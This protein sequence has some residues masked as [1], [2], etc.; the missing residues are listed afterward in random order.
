MYNKLRTLAT[1]A[2]LAL[3][4]VR[5]IGVVSVTMVPEPGV[6]SLD[7]PGVDNHSRA[8]EYELSLDDVAPHLRHLYPSLGLRYLSI[9]SSENVVEINGELVWYDEG[10][11]PYIVYGRTLQR[12]EQQR[13]AFEAE[14]A[15]R[16]KIEAIHSS[17]R[18][19]FNSIIS[20]VSNLIA[21]TP[22][23][24]FDFVD[25]TNFCLFL[26]VILCLW[27]YV[28][29]VSAYM[30]EVLVLRCRASSV[31]RST[32]MK[33]TGHYIEEGQVFLKCE[34]YLGKKTC[35]IVLDGKVSTAMLASA[36]TTAAADA[37]A[38][39]NNGTSL[40]MSTQNASYPCRAPAQSA[41]IHG[42]C[43]K[44]NLSGD[45]FG[46]M[47]HL[48]VEGKSYAL[49]A[50]HVFRALKQQLDADPG[51]KI[52]VRTRNGIDVPLPQGVVYGMSPVSSMDFLLLEL[53]KS[54]WAVSGIKSIKIAKKPVQRHMK[55][56]VRT[57]NPDGT[58]RCSYGSALEVHGPQIF[59]HSASTQRGASGSPIISGGVCYGIHTRALPDQRTNVATCL[60]RLLRGS[61]LLESEEFDSLDGPEDPDD[62]LED[63]HMYGS[64]FFY[65]LKSEWREQRS[66]GKYF[67][68]EPSEEKSLVDRYGEE[69][70]LG[71][72]LNDNYV[73]G[74][75]WGDYE[76]GYYESSQDFQSGPRGQPIKT[77][78]P[79]EQ[80]YPEPKKPTST[81]EVRKETLETSVEPAKLPLVEQK[82]EL[83]TTVRPTRPPMKRNQ[84]LTTA[85]ES[86]HTPVTKTQ[87]LKTSVKPGKTTASP[88]KAPPSTKQSILESTSGATSQSTTTNAGSDEPQSA[89]P[90][91]N[92]GRR[93]RRR[94]KRKK[95]LQDSTTGTPQSQPPTRP[96][97]P[98]TNKAQ[99]V[100][101]EL[102][103]QEKS[104]LLALR[105]SSRSTAKPKAQEDSGKES[106][107]K[108]YA[109][110]A[111][112]SSSTKSTGPPNQECPTRA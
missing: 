91:G 49:T 60:S 95:K 53:P 89:S 110:V 63:E 51:R 34:D 85:R 30:W 84:K 96:S 54:F 100:V 17:L 52:H 79:Q 61:V 4:S 75:K 26:S 56:E 94:R 35:K 41:V 78:A 112:S 14:K 33:V 68:D 106:T 99:D 109:A 5:P 80:K 21:R 43:G 20:P 47:T 40:E 90:Q 22:F 83:H 66:N 67:R 74:M 64:K 29:P 69:I 101:L 23:A 39:D 82:E 45:I 108:S 15:Y 11:S 98:S 107:S 13:A 59:T 42:S 71:N 102:S 62:P 32:Y 77:E 10:T 28:G 7:M 25:W 37:T 92:S 1:F 93:K 88:Q 87:T 31:Q 44:A 73:A 24:E 111:G 16:K 58:W 48:S 50:A 86:W 70:D 38:S 6:G 19:A 12:R 65:M 46:V 103:P 2:V 36:L 8:E 57:P 104:F 97:P 3:L 9:I 105:S 72:P 55:L 18:N 76:E 27:Y 81:L